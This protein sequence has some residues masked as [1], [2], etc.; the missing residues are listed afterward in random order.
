MAVVARARTLW[1]EGTEPGRPVAAMGVAIALS[2]VVVEL[3]AHGRLG[4]FFDLVFVL[5]CCAMALRVRP[6]DFFLIGVL[7]PLLML[8]VF[9]LLALASSATIADEVDGTIQAVITGLANHSGALISGYALCLGAL[10]MRQQVYR[11]RRDARRTPR[12]RRPVPN[13]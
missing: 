7:P 9:W 4:W 1:E 6:S 8:S 10:A 3:V 12:G 13:L 2:A 11:K 5:T